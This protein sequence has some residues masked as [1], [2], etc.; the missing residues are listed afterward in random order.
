MKNTIK[1]LSLIILAI[2]CGLIWRLEVENYG[3]AGLT[4]TRYFHWAIPFDVLLFVIWSNLF[5]SFK[6]GKR[7][8]YNTL[9]LP[10]AFLSLWL[11]QEILYI[12]YGA[13]FGFPLG[14]IL[15][16]AIILFSWPTGLY[17]LLRF[18]G[19]DISTKFLLLSI[20]LVFASFPIAMGLLDV[21]NHKGN[22]DEL[23]AIK[24]GFVIPMIVFSIGFL[25]V[26]SRNS[27]SSPSPS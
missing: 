13:R 2:T 11:L 14:M 6:K 18:C 25:I 22:D 16:P 21:V 12:M 23:H 1:W 5:L 26:K 9:G 3:W 27:Q 7:L 17:L 19:F 8:L 10:F 24:S 20:L 15:A 4:W